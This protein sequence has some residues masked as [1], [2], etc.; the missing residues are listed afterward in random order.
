VELQISVPPLVSVHIY[1]INLEP[2]DNTRFDGRAA[3]GVLWTREYAAQ[4]R[5]A[6]ADGR[7]TLPRS[8]LHPPQSM[9]LSSVCGDTIA[10]RSP[11]HVVLHVQD[12]KDTQ[13]TASRH[14][15]A[16]CDSSMVRTVLLSVLPLLRS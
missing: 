15:N 16:I 7:I 11:M 12:S 3:C 8:Y 9:S 6:S 14:R 10:Y 5:M 1:S 2:C 4:G 13:P